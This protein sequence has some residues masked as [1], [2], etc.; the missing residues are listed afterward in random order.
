MLNLNIQQNATSRKA[1]QGNSIAYFNGSQEYWDDQKLKHDAFFL[2][3][4]QEK[5]NTI[6][7]WCECNNYK[8]TMAVEPNL[9]VDVNF[10]DGNII[11]QWQ[12]DLTGNGYVVNL[13]ANVL[14]IS[15]P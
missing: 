5:A 3:I 4:A 13:D 1:L 15:L 9:I 11:T 8:D 6:C 7:Q 10:V 14:T 12:S 2:T